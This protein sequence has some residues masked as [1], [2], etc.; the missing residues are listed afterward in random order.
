MSAALSYA[1]WAV[2][3]AVALGLWARSRSP[4]A[5]VARPAVV[6]GRLAT[7]PLSRIVLVLVWIWVGWH[8]FAR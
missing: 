8:L 6:V 5:S 2:L 1:V 3:G 7:G 4:G